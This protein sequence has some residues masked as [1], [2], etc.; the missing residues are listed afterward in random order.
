MT[1]EN[2]QRA[3]Q[4]P[5]IRIVPFVGDHSAGAWRLSQQAGWPHRPED[6]ALTLS[7]SNGVVALQG[8]T[9]VG[10][11]LAT[12]F[13]TVAMLNMIIV[14][15]RLRG[16]GLGRR[17]MEEVV[18]FAGTREMRLVATEEG[19]PLYRK[20]GFVEAGEIFQYQGIVRANPVP[21]ATVSAGG[22]A[23]VARLAAMDEA[24]SGLAR[25]PLLKAIAA[26]G[27]VLVAPRG[28]A[29]LRP[30]GRGH[31]LGP[32]V[33]ADA[34]TARALIVTAAARLPGAFLRIDLPTGC[35]LGPFVEALGLALAGR[36][37]AMRRPADPAAPPP[38]QGPFTTYALAA[39]ALG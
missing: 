36:G 23:E 15:A 24:A 4:A 39:Q 10:T 31:V 32:V 30:F 11:A 17:L 20:M 12:I 27:E 33:A 9:V 25:A 14:D 2:A 16:Q 26:R 1:A 19:M 3:P 7:V 8:G 29:M 21:D 22:A 13:G 35:G 38:P 34:A 28:F 18:A 37:T 5:A 6:W